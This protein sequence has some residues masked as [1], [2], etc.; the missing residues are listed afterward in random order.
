MSTSARPPSFAETVEFVRR[1]SGHGV[2][3]IIVADTRL[4]SDL[5]ITGDD[6]S[7]LLD[8]AGRYFGADLSGHDGFRTTFGLAPNEYLFHAEGFDLVGASKVMGNIPPIPA[9][10]SGFDRRPI[11]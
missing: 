9:S 1:F 7:D 11:A 3:T 2:K 8:E 6:G 4:D 10:G 5:G